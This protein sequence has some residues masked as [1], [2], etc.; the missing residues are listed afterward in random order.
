MNKKIFLGVVVIFVLLAIFLVL[1]KKE[2]Q[3]ELPN[4]LDEIQEI[5]MCYSY[6][7]E[8]SFGLKDQAWLKTFIKGEFI[9]GEYHNVPAEKDSKTGTFEGYVYTDATAP[10]TFSDVWWYSFSEGVY[11][12]EQLYLSFDNDGVSALFGEMVDRGDGVYV[13]KDTENLTKEFQMSEIDC[14]LLNKKNASNSVI[15]IGE[16]SNPLIPIVLEDDM[17][18]CTM[19]AMICPDGSYVGRIGPNCAFQACPEMGN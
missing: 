7:K 14:S 8:A 2:K 1:T 9:K 13:Y 15:K 11:T 5:A 18:V 10:G 4:Q 16:E 3:I 17:I 6:E 12:M 19:D